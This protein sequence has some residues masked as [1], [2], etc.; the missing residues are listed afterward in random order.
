[1]QINIRPL[2]KDFTLPAYA[3]PYDAGMDLTATTVINDTENNI[4]RYKV[5][6]A[7]DIPKGFVGYIF[8]RSSISKYDLAMCNSVGVID[9]GYLDEVEVRM[10]P[11]KKDGKYYGF[12]DRVAQLIVMPVPE[13][14][15]NVVDNFNMSYDRGGGFGHTGK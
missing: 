10:R 1:L 6:F 9:S 8:P 15:F 13:V 3:K 2:H 11:T 12:G 5:G 7:V 4:I 14:Q